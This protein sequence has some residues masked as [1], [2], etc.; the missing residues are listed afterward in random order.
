MTAVLTILAIIFTLS[1][2]AT[3]YSFYQ[4][5]TTIFK[6]KGMFWDKALDNSF[7]VMVT[8][9]ALLILLGLLERWL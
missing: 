6:A 8:S 9:A 4:V 2:V 5:E 7:A 3:G 1:L